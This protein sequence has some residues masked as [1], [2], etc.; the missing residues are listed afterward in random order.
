MLGFD[1]WLAEISIDR[2][3]EQVGDIHWKQLG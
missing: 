2:H 1:A 3:G